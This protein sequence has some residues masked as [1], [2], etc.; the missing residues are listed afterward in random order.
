[1]LRFLPLIIFAVPC[2]SVPAE[3]AVYR[4]FTT[5]P[6][7]FVVPADSPGPAY[8][9]GRE[10]RWQETPTSAGPRPG[11]AQVRLD[12]AQVSNGK[13]WLVVNKPEWIH[14]VHEGTRRLVDLA[15][16]RPVYAWI[17]TSRG[18]QWTGPLAG[19]KR[20]TPTHIRAEVWMA[21]CRGATAVGYFTHVWK[22]A[23]NQFGVPAANRKA[24]RQINDQIT[25][26]APEIL[27]GAPK[28]PV[29]VRASGDVK[30]DVMARA[31][32]GGLTVFTVNYDERLK[33]TEAVVNVPGLRA[34]TELVV[35]DENRTIRSHAGGFADTFAPLAVH[36]Y[37][38]RN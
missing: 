38:I 14:L 9:K 11:T 3:Y 22:P 13:T 20:V 2:A 36:I 6:V 21:I 34:G 5:A 28:Q 30:V 15:G 17:E 8:F 32:R 10:G 37:R 23:Y 7:R 26:L 31:A 33:R 35:V 24:L 19:Q 27:A 1:M 18:G 16:D 12:T 29:T 4:V 25:R